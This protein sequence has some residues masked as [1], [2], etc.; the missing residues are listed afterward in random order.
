MNKL[1]LLLFF[2]ACCLHAS[3]H[4]KI[5]IGNISFKNATVVDPD[6]A[7]F[8]DLKTL[9]VPI[10]RA[11]N[12]IIVEAQVDTLEGNFVLDTGAP[13]LVLNET[14]FRD[15]PKIDDQDA[16]GINGQAGLLGVH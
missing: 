16:G 9:V 15:A 7:P 5:T 11:G 6:P 4:K 14:Y 12:L 3:A 2:M 1:Y 8:A 13:Y 10:K